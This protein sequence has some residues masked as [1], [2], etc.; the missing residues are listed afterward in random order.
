VNDF[1]TIGIETMTG[2]E[3]DSNS[4]TA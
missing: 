2:T 1:Y 3:D 4:K